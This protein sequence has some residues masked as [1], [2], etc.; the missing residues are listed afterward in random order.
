M[1]LHMD[2]FPL[3]ENLNVA[4]GNNFVMSFAALY[5]GSNESEPSSSDRKMDVSIEH[6]SIS[7]Q[8]HTYDICNSTCRSKFC[9]KFHN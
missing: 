5:S 6:I 1:S 2:T 4:I 3:I 8:Q 7:A 9:G